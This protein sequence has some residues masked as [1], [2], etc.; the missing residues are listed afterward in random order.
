M[1]RTPVRVMC[2]GKRC[3]QPQKGPGQMSVLE[4]I[5]V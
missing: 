4:P 2:T 3:P 1:I 5:L